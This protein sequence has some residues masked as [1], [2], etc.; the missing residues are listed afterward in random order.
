MFRKIKKRA[1]FNKLSK[2]GRKIVNTPYNRNDFV[3]TR[4]NEVNKILGENKLS[5]N[6]IIT[7]L[8]RGIEP[9]M[10]IY[11]DCFLIS[12]FERYT[13]GV[14]NFKTKKIIIPCEFYDVTF[15]KNNIIN[16]LIEVNVVDIN[17]N[18]INYLLNETATIKKP[19][20]NITFS[21]PINKFSERFGFSQ[22]EEFKKSSNNISKDSITKNSTTVEITK[23]II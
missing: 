19:T 2:L 6:E 7:L 20:S 4:F 21:S 5:K 1:K 8:D 18:T 17:N 3:N 14:A 9:V 16:D 22:N 23:E 12:N 13:F 10:H 15:D 11:N